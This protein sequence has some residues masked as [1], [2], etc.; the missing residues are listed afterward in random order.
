MP[1]TIEE[2]ALNI[3]EHREREN[4]INA[5]NPAIA[6]SFVNFNNQD[7]QFWLINEEN[8]GGGVPI[9]DINGVQ[10]GWQNGPITTLTNHGKTIYKN[11]PLG[12]ILIR[13]YQGFHQFNTPNGIQVIEI[14]NVAKYY[15]SIH[16]NQ[17]AIDVIIQLSND[18]RF[19]SYRSISEILR[20]H[21][22]IQE[23]ER[24][25][26]KAHDDELDNLLAELEKLE[27]ERTEYLQKAQSFIR[28]YSELRYQPILDAQQEEIKRS[29]IFQGTLVINGG[30]GTGK[31]TSLIQR[32][33]FLISR[34]ILEYIDLNQIQKKILFEQNNNW[35]FLSPNELLALYLRNSI[36]KEGLKGYDSNVLMW[37]KYKNF[38]LKD[39]QYITENRRPFL[40]YDSK[41]EMDGQQLLINNPDCIADTIHQFSVFL[42][43]ERIEFFKSICEF[44][45]SS[46][47]WK[48]IGQSIQKYLKENLNFNSFEDL[49]R[50]FYFLE[51][52]FKEAAK[53]L[54]KKYI[55]LL[56]RLGGQ[57][58]LKIRSD[59]NLYS[60]LEIILKGWKEKTLRLNEE[61][62]ESDDEDEQEFEDSIQSYNFE[63]D[64]FN[65]IKSILR[66]IYL[67]EFDKKVTLTKKD[68]ILIDKIPF[69]TTLDDKNKEVG[70]VA[71][72]NKYFGVLVS[73]IERN[74]FQL[75]PKLYK[76][77]RKECLKDN[78]ENWNLELLKQL[79]SDGNVRLHS[80]EQS[81]IIYI[82]NTYC[83]KLYSSFRTTFINSTHPFINGFKNNCKPII[84]ID[85]ATDF[86]II[87]LI[88]MESLGHYDLKSVTFSGDLMQRLSKNGLNQWEDLERFVTD[89]KVSDLQTSYRQSPTL[90]DLAKEIYNQSNQK[91]PDY[92]SFMSYDKLEPKPLI[93]VSDDEEAKIN[94]IAERIVEIYIAYG[95]LIPS[96]AVFLPFEKQID[97]FSTKLGC[98]RFLADIGINVTP[99][100]N[101]E[102]LGDAK[103]VRVFSASVIKGLEFEAVFF[104][105]FDEL[106]K[107]DIS[108]D[109]LQKYLYV[110]L[111]RA[112][113][114]LGM[115]LKSELPD[116]LN[117]LNEH[118]EKR[119]GS[120]KVE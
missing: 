66:K 102:V 65:K 33:K 77:F 86:P 101:G 88:A 32:I 12:E 54:N 112:T 13:N 19:Y 5:S 83:K 42:I 6:R 48:R 82:T 109:L 75:I 70:E 29:N 14:N 103:S 91:V 118:F 25:I 68:K 2:I 15:P 11:L 17:L 95:T 104:H 43:N 120:W 99:C 78:S 56:S 116:D 85:E 34:S 115:T 111:S 47:A 21:Q 67:N 89:I 98:N 46:F 63:L 36:T 92:T 60:N 27:Q 69:L 18:P 62:D 8:F 90:V 93:I 71:F 81:F 114:Y 87:D 35:I 16:N 31:T 28:N 39:Y 3:K 4:A 97:E 110:G 76:N 79:I 80:N 22:Q 61:F 117:Y 7:Q 1:E 10:V 49:L 40:V 41:K 72:F 9:L 38:L 44:E 24:L 108:P 23:T 107:L 57:V 50:I 119:K 51:S 105:N 45:L 55:D 20:R 73:G 53:G 100:R 74:L 94:W 30:P 26:N 113:F 106:L 37:E 96:I 84:G 52:E 64:L 58:L 59:K